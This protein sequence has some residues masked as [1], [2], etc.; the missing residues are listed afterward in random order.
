MSFDPIGSFVSSISNPTGSPQTE[1]ADDP[2]Q[3][4]KDQFLKLLLAQLEQ[5]DPFE[6][7]DASEFARQMTSFGQL[8]QLFNLNAT[9]ESQQVLSQR[10][11]KVQSANYVGKTVQA[12]GS[13]FQIDESGSGQVGFFVADD[14]AAVRVGVFNAVGEQVATLDYS[15]VAAG[16]HSFEFNSADELG[17]AL[18][19][20]NYRIE[21]AAQDAEEAPIEVAPLIQGEVTEVA[22]DSFGPVIMVGEQVFRLEDIVAI[23]S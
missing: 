9:M 5:Q 8:E 18:P 22:Y 12:G 16:S 11:E 7:Q 4:T 6:A 21:V 1:Q 14:A 10:L 17:T 13:V 19:G 20:G 23:K 3:T 2:Y 15:D